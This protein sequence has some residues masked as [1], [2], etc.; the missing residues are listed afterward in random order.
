M[1]VLTSVYLRID[2]TDRYHMISDRNRTSFVRRSGALR[3]GAFREGAFRGRL[4]AAPL[5]GCVEHSLPSTVD[6]HC[7]GHDMMLVLSSS[8]PSLNGMG[9]GAGGVY[10]GGS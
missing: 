5:G 10:S 4:P 6:V 2:A 3:E 9:A 8:G 1:P 7:G